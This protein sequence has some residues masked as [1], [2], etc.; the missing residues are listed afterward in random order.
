MDTRTQ[1]QHQKDFMSTFFP[2]SA[3]HTNQNAIDSSQQH[4]QTL[5]NATLPPNMLGNGMHPSSNTNMPLDMD[6]LG[7][8]MAM[9]GMETQAALMSNQQAPYNPQALLEQQFKL[10]QLQQ[11]Q[12]LQN[13]IFQQQASNF[14]PYVKRNR[15][16]RGGTKRGFFAGH[17]VEDARFADN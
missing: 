8:L 15:R 7:N 10:T 16:L 1:D 3:D 4:Q 17:P 12:Q 9:Q 5:F 14:F 11:L 6:L 13:Q 2:S